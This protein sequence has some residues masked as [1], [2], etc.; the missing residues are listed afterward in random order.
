MNLR[1]IALA[2]LL[3][4]GCLKH[5]ALSSVA[6][7]L[8]GT[9]TTFSSDDDLELVR[10]ATPFA[11]K[12]MESLIPELPD[13]QGI[14]LAACSGFAEYAFA[15]VLQPAQMSEAVSVQRHGAERA[16]KLFVRAN[17]YCLDALEIAHEGFKKSLPDLRA[18]KT[19]FLAHMTK[20]DIAAMYWT[21][22]SAAL[23]VTAQK[24]AVDRIADLPVVDAL[25]RRAVA[26]DADWEHGTLH[27][28]LVSW[29]GG[30]SPSM[31]GSVER[32]RVAFHRAVKLTGGKHAAPYVSLA[33]NVAVAAQDK[34][35]FEALLKAAL[36]IDVDSA[37]NDRL[38][39]IVAQNRARYLL[40]HEDDLIL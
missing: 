9:G 30:R 36:A 37:P 7:G 8:S 18:G 26:L 16:K 38:A 5:L 28:F 25:I 14:H 29:D 15:F 2:S 3:F 20:D 10:D 27:E 23:S 19:A 34:K 40:A 11:L 31:G 39:N 1:S 22:A 24:E 33:E 12:T 4:S 13:H 17:G 21:A 6:D 35:E 32:A